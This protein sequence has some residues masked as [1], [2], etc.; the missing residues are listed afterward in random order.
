M[1]KRKKR[2]SECITNIEVITTSDKK[3]VLDKIALI[4]VKK[5]LAACAQVLGP[6]ESTYWWKG[7]IEHSKEYMLVIKTK[8]SVYK[9]VEKEILGNHNYDLPQITTIKISGS[10]SYL[11]WI[12]KA[13]K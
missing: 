2:K 5:K 12:N 10:H 8:R 4:L 11:D 1:K 9:W 7:K 6:V 3:E 13:V